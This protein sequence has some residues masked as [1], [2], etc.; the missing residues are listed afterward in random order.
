MNAEV[1]QLIENRMRRNDP[2]D[3]KMSLFRQQ[4]CIEFYTSATPTIHPPRCIHNCE[5]VVAYHQLL[6]GI[7]IRVASQCKLT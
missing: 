4:V 2:I 1:N 6:Q 3:D 5:G 7:C